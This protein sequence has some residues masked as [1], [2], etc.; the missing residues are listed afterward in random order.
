[1]ALATWAR[2]DTKWSE[3]GPISKL[4]RENIERAWLE[5][6]NDGNES[7]LGIYRLSARSAPNI[8]LPYHNALRMN[9]AN[10][11]SEYLKTLAAPDRQAIRVE[12]RKDDASGANQHTKHA[13]VVHMKEVVEKNV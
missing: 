2:F 11:T 9:K 13:Q 7:D 8:S 4:T 6:T 10:H 5:V 3:D 12:V 1:G